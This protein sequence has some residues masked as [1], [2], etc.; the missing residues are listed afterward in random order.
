MKGGMALLRFDEYMARALYGP[1]GFYAS[2]G[3]AGR[4]RGDFI[5]SPEIGPLFGAVLAEA[6]DHW[7]ASA[8]SPEGFTVYDV[9]CG[10]GALLKAIR[11]A[12]P[13]RPWELVGVDP[14]NDAADLNELPDDLAGSV[15][16]ANELLDNLPFRIVERQADGF[17]EVFVDETGEVLKP[18]TLEPDG[19]PAR[20]DPH[21]TM[22]EMPAGDRAPLLADAAAWVQNTLARNPLVL[23]LFDYGA[24]TTVELASRGGWLRT[25]RQHQRGSDP[26][27]QPGSWDI[28][29]D[30]GWDQL[31]TP[32]ELQT[33]AQFLRR[34]SI[35]RLVEEGRSHWKANAHAPDL[36]AMRMR[37]RISEAEALLDPESLG[38]WWVATWGT[39]P[40]L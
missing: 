15:V 21:R 22:V 33:Q 24:P 1:G 4:R 35:E 39:G 40:G 7:W 12:R 16:V 36:A 6:I 9:G 23:C 28:T 20:N 13:D 17:T 19:P 26:Y 31:P 37:S 3:T 5:T 10:P 29:T 27:D 34:W 32:D 8:G 25:Y 2:E 14:A 30:I 11:V 18:L 38:R